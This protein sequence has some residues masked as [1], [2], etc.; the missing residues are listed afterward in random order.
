[1]STAECPAEVE[2]LIYAGDPEAWLLLDPKERIEVVPVFLELISSKSGAGS[3]AR[4]LRTSLNLSMA[5]PIDV[6]E[7]KLENKPSV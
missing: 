4:A 3:G 7:V 5:V 6:E 1:M 2:T